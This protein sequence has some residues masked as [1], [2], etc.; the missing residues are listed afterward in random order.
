MFDCRCPHVPHSDKL[1]AEV[2]LLYGRRAFL[3]GAAAAGAA[4]FLPWRA[5]AAEQVTVLKAAR[6]F[7]G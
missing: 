5:R 1:F 2:E 4:L 3:L 7:D 6:L